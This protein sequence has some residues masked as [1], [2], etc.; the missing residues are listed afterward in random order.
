MELL[1]W[2]DESKLNVKFLNQNENALEYLTK[3]Q[4]IMFPYVFRN[5]SF[6]VLPQHSSNDMIPDM[7]LNTRPGIENILK[8]INYTR[9]DW[10]NMCQNPRCIDMI[11][12]NPKYKY[13]WDSLSK[14]PK[15]IPLLL[16]NIEHIDWSNLC[17]NPCK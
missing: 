8:T 6:V 3:F 16:K 12:P 2:I 13:A 14:N 4:L 7:F 5:H 9:Y 15:A 11:H 17:M 1:P 10:Q